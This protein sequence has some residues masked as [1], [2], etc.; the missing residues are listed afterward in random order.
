VKIYKEERAMTYHKSRIILVT[1]VLLLSLLVAGSSCDN[2]GGLHGTY[3]LSQMGNEL[4]ITFKGDRCTTSIGSLWYKYKYQLDYE[5]ND[6]NLSDAVGITL[7][8]TITG[9]S[10]Y[11]TFKY[12]ED[13]N[14]IIFDGVMYYKE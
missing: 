13:T 2:S 14:A 6:T 10:A 5:G 8:D 7:T 3:S 1:I 11:H 4:S 9:L 12:I